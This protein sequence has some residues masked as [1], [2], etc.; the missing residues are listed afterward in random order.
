MDTDD[1]QDD[2]TDLPLDDSA[3]RK[4]GTQMTKPAGLALDM[5]ALRLSQ[6]A[7]AA[8]ES[9]NG[10]HMSTKP[11]AA[12]VE[13]KNKDKGKQRLLVDDEHDDD[14]HS[15]PIDNGYRESDANSDLDAGDDDDSDNG[16]KVELAIRLETMSKHQIKRLCMKQH[17]KIKQL[18]FNIKTLE[19]DL[20]SVSV[21]N[22]MDDD[23]QREARN[24]WEAELQ[25][26]KDRANE[27]DAERRKAAEATE[28]AK[29]LAAALEASARC[30]VTL[31]TLANSDVSLWCALALMTILTIKTPPDKRRPIALPPSLW[32]RRSRP[33]PS[34]SKASGCPC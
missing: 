19:K 12:I 22:A 14:A 3:E 15:E 32:R 8:R 17:R 2:F 16:E 31:H 33:R 5:A 24:E 6:S 13:A 25:R 10:H 30:R 7:E 34:N 29:A 11:A 27:R 26:Q 18:R 4:L 20:K 9:T 23:W 1:D 21:A 28:E